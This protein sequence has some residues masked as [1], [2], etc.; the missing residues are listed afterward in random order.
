MDF[1]ALGEYYNQAHCVDRDLTLCLLEAC[2]PHSSSPLLVCEAFAAC[3]VRSLRLALE[4]S[5]SLCVVANDRGASAIETITENAKLNGIPVRMLPAASPSTAVAEHAQPGTVL[6]H[7]GEANEF[8]LSLPAHS[9]DVV[10]LD[11]FGCAAPYLEAAVHATRPGGVLGV[12]TFDVRDL[13][14]KGSKGFEKWGGHPAS[15][16]PCR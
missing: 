10:D 7:R 15:A 5:Q 14:G 2:V 4:L 8:L 9:F 12:T 13:K 6:C 1:R 16:L 3:G 11:P